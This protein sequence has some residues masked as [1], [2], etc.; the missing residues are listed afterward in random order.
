MEVIQNNE[1]FNVKI[2][3]FRRDIFI[4]QDLV[5]EIARIYGY[6]KIPSLEL[7]SVSADIG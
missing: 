4:K 7:T 1:N 3:T 5:E 2:P 6:D